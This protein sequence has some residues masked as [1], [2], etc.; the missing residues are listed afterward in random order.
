MKTR[1]SFL[2]LIFLIA[3]IPSLKSQALHD[4]LF[5]VIETID[6]NEF[7]GILIYRDEHEVKIETELLGV[8]SIPIRSVKSLKEI[9]EKEFQGG[10]YWFRNPHSSRYFYGPSGYGLKRGEGYYQNT[11][12][13]FNQVSMGFSDHFTMGAG[14]I[15]AFLFGGSPTPAWLTPKISIPLIKDKI[16]LG[17]GALIATIIGERESGLGILFGTITYGS[18]DKNSTLGLGWAYSS[19]GFGDYPT[20]SLSGMVRTGKKGY[21]LTENYLISTEWET[22]GILSAGGRYVQ[23]KMAID[24]GLFLPVN[25][26]EFFAIPWLGITLP[27]GQQN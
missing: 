15:P 6:G 18:I 7:Q 22:I 4:S 24:Y 26:G 2:L 23:K 10:E 1:K 8:V 13:F 14:F 21:F 17:A 20:L 27:F 19:E 16:N 25:V 5:V 12:V 9:N 11:W 3:F